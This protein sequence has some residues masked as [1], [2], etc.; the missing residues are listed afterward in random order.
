MET[1][2]PVRPG[3]KV[4]CGASVAGTGHRKS[5]TPCQD[6]WGAQHLADDT[7][8]MAVAD[9]FGSAVHGGDGARIA[10]AAAIGAVNDFFEP[11]CDDGELPAWYVKNRDIIRAG[12]DAAHAAI[13]TVAGETGTPPREYACTLILVLWSGSFCTVGQ[14]GDG[15]VV[16]KTMG[17]LACISSPQKGEYV[18]ETFS[19]SAPEYGQHLRMTENVPGISACALFTDGLERSLLVKQ[20]NT[21]EPYGPFFSPAFIYLE[22]LSDTTGC[23]DE[24][25]SFLQ[26]E[27]MQVQSDDDMTLVMGIA[28]EGTCDD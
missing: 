7:V 24:I 9:G 17:G 11:A 16:V 26:S 25:A 2:H 10:V 6:A 20:G 18:N 28:K 14:I 1:D 5:G 12:I 15:G 4:I 3:S 21:W 13:C 22:T 27:R 8:V 19:L 23:E